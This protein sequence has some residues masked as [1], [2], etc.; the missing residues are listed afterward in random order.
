MAN[1]N[2]PFG[3]LE[4]QGG[5]GGAPTFAQTERR[6]A[7]SNTTPIYFGDPVM[8][9]TSPANGYITQAAAGTSVIDGIFVGCKYLSVSQQRTIWSRYWPGSDASGDVYAYV[10][11]DPNAR[12]LVQSSW[13]SPLATSLTTFGSSPVGQYCQFNIGS[14]NAS[15]GQSGAYVDT[16]G[17]TIT[18]PF[19]V[20]D[21]QTFPPGAN[22]ADPTTRYYNV[23]VGFNNEWLRTNGAGPTGIS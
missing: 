18:Y 17:T 22:G 8:P 15:T 10:I 6:I 11:D 16:L 5:A 20:V 1:T 9:V 7:A 14:G 19:I 2:S 13:T 23:V 3:F 21:L 12:F 4:Y